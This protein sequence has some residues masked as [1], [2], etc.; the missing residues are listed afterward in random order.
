MARLS[1]AI[2]ASALA[3]SA[4]T[5]IVQ[6]NAPTP[7]PVP[8]AGTL[9][10]ADTLDPTTKR[11]EIFVD[12]RIGRTTAN[13]SK[14]YASI[15]ERTAV[16]LA[17][18]KIVTTRA[19]L[20]RLDERPVPQPLLGAWGCNLDDPRKLAPETV[21]DFYATKGDLDSSPI[22]CATDPLVSIGEDLSRVVTNYPPEIQGR[23]GQRV[24]SDEPPSV[25]LVIHI[26]D[27]ERRSGWGDAA[28][29]GAKKLLA[30]DAAGNAAWLA[31]AGGGITADRVI[32]WFL[33]TDELVDRDTFVAECKRYQAPV[34]ALDLIDPSDRALYG[35]LGDAIDGEGAGHVARLPLCAALSDSEMN[36]FLKDQI[37]AIADL[38]GTSVNEDVLKRIF[39]GK[40]IPGVP[41]SSVS[42]QG[43]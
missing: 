39:D 15:V 21:M 23:N 7:V 22:G 38:V 36:K 24:F 29:E 42:T 27:R 6:P 2:A 9:T 5:I 19:V 41:S 32:H 10:C 26:D 37:H 16:V 14:T 3:V 34:D 28:C 17:A 43:N 18:A 31:Y 20:I 12:V 35:P 25:A 11:A 40:A 30:K 1:P 4:C 13:L 33:T 8:G